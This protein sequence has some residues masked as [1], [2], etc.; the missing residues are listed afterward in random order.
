M[1]QV[2]NSINSPLSL[3]ND[4]AEKINASKG[5]SVLSGGI[6][7]LYLFMNLLSEM[8]DAKYSQM[9]SKADV[10]REAQSKANEVDEIIAGMLKDNSTDKLPPDVVKYMQDNGITVDGVSITEYLKA[11]DPAAP[12]LDK[13]KSKIE[14]S[15]PS[16]MQSYSWQDVVSYMDKHGIKVDGKRACDYIWSL[17]EVGYQ[18]G[19]R[20]SKAH[21][22]HMY[23]ALESASGL[24]KG[25]MQ[26][27]KAALETVSNRAS[28]FVSQSQLQLQKI[29]QTYNVTVSL[30]NS[31]QTMLAE[32]NKSIAQN[33]R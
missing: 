18:S 12:F 3:H 21:M 29:M 23:D 5:D 20:I 13:L 9:Q 22:Q 14:E 25:K 24:D 6:A 11:N 27:V 15:G 7:V 2:D 30:V 19:Q 28:D 16:G 1:Y 31:M 4:K 8:A 32:M 33:I 17:P 26:A 10:S